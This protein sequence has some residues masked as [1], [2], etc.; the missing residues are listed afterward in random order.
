MRAWH[1]EAFGAPAEV[2]RLVQV[3]DLQP[4]AG[5]VA[6]RVAACTLGF[7][8]V[9]MCR[10]GYQ[11]RPTLPFSPGADFYGEI[12]SVGPGVDLAARDLSVG[13]KVIAIGAGLHGGLADIALVN[14]DLL[15]PAP[16]CLDAAESAALFGAYLTGWLALTHSARI[17]AGEVLL[18]HAAAGGVGSAAVQLGLAA[19]A[20]VIGV[21]RGERKAEVVRDLGASLVIDRDQVSVIEAVKDATKG[22]GA[23]IVYDPV[24]GSSWFESTKC[25]AFEGRLLVIGFAGGEILSQPLNHP[26]VKNYSII[27]I[28][29]GLYTVKRPDVVARAM[30][31]L[32]NLAAGRAIRPLIGERVPLI[33]APRALQDLDDG[34]TVGRSVVMLDGSVG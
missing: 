32:S 16:A 5:Q 14:L 23:D 21:T 22:R 8:D 24:G 12:V 19:G 7:P 4:G 10:A 9:L 17:Q 27:G 26:L 34:V 29:S 1:V 28:N 20:T 33:D 18:V 11:H 3:P 15:F 13:S 2:M 31:E 30:A 25:V 6:V